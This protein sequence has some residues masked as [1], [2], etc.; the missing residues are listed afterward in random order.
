[1][2]EKTILVVD[3][4]PGIV[5]LMA[6]MLRREGFA[7]VAAYTG[8][9]ALSQYERQR[10]ALILLDLAMP[11]MSGFEVAQEIRRREQGKARTPIVVLTAHA[12]SYYV[13]RQD[14][15]DADGY[16][17]KPLTMEKLRSELRQLI[18]A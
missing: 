17:T 15:L 4:D 1:M 18:P 10:P 5:T 13:S 6:T 2:T 9:E 7:T 12:Q 16:I 8:E 14:E 3:D 11:G